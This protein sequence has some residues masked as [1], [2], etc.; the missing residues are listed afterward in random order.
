MNKDSKIYVSGHLGLV[1]SALLKKLQDQNYYNIVTKTKDLDLKIQANVDLFF[2]KHRPE[3]VFIA[4]QKLVGLLL[5]I[6]NSR[7]SI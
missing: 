7:I 5:I 1:G 6:I 2:K 3:Y 4:L